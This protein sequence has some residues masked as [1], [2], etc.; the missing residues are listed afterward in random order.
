MRSSVNYVKDQSHFDYPFLA[1]LNETG[2][3]HT[4]L[5][6]K[7]EYDGDK[8]LRRKKYGQGVDGH[9]QYPWE[10]DLY[11][12]VRNPDRLD[13][14]YILTNSS[15]GNDQAAAS[16][17]PGDLGY[18]SEGLDGGGAGNENFGRKLYKSKKPCVEVSQ[19]DRKRPFSSLAVM[20]KRGKRVSFENQ[21]NLRRNR[22]GSLMRGDVPGYSE[23][24][25][26]GNNDLNEG[27]YQPYDEDIGG[28]YGKRLHSAEPRMR[29]KKGSEGRYHHMFRKGKRV[30]RPRF[31]H[32]EYS[33][34]DRF[35]RTA[36]PKT[37]DWMYQE[38]F[39]PIRQKLTP[40]I[41]RGRVPRLSEKEREKRSK[42][43]YCKV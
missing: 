24:G 25:I 34:N 38:T 17:R 42:Q 35:A 39:E 43:L 12:K 21:K 27:N 22:R 3:D 18:E 41:T 13:D 8:G 20:K 30:D 6:C 11:W 14:G 19:I 36:Y 16:G 2:F 10:G 40:K 23:G 1:H 33:L 37:G 5:I 15:G 29:A 31:K 4:G 7:R 32:R 28:G 9:V 26:E